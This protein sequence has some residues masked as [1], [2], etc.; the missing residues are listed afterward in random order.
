[1]AKVNGLEKMTYAELAELRENVDAAMA[2]AK[3]AERKALIAKMEELA[4]EAGL[5][6]AEVIGGKRSLK[7]K[8]VAI[9][10]RNPKDDSQTWTGRGRKPTWLVEATKKGHKLEGFLV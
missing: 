4:A 10:Y 5:T 8:T 1:M 9:K 7:G 2:A 3:V 6:M